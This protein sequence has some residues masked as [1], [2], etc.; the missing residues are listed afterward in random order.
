[1]EMITVDKIIE[2]QTR[3][4]MRSTLPEDLGFEGELRDQG[5]LEYIVNEG[6]SKPNAISK[7]S[8]F[9]HKI[10]TEH[11][12]Y[13]GNKRTALLTALLILELDPLAYQINCTNEEVA[14]F[15][16]KVARYES[17]LEE[18]EQWIRGKIN[19]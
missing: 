15:V 19:V 5:T 16:I 11:P 10:A 17:S 7:A 1:M 14:D 9:L 12:F 8:W 18:V 13:Q 3:A 2:I 4:I 6:N